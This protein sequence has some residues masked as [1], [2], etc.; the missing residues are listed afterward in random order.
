VQ[1]DG[2]QR[3]ALPAWHRE[4]VLDYSDLAKK[5]YEMINEKHGTDVEPLF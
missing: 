3:I 4:V 5:L 2:S 1:F